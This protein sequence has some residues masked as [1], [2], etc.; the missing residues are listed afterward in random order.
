M[1]LLKKL[2]RKL[3]VIS[4]WW[5]NISSRCARKN[6][7]VWAVFI[8]TVVAGFFLSSKIFAVFEVFSEKNLFNSEVYVEG[9]MEPYVMAE[10]YGSRF[11]SLN[12]LY[13]RDW[14]AEVIK[15]TKHKEASPPVVARYLAYTASI[16]ADV[17]NE[18]NSQEQANV[19][20]AQFLKV[21]FPEKTREISDVLISFNFEE[22]ELNDEAR[23]VFNVYSDRLQDDGFNIVWN[24]ETRKEDSWYVQNESNVDKGAAAGE[25]K[26]WIVDKNFVDVSPPPKRGSLR[27]IVEINRAQHLIDHRQP[28]EEEGIF[29]W[30][31]VDNIISME[32]IT[33]AGIWQ[34]ILYIELGRTLDDATY[35]Q[36]QKLLS[37]SIADSLIVVWDVK[38]THLVQRPFMRIPRL[39]ILYSNP[40]YPSYPSSDAAVSVAASEVLSLLVPEKRDLWVK[41]AT[42][43]M[44]SV[45]LAGVNFDSDVVAGTH[46]GKWVAEEIL[47]NNDTQIHLDT[48][49]QKNKFK[50][51]YSNFRVVKDFLLLKTQSA[52]A[53]IVKFLKGEVQVKHFM[54]AT[55]E[56]GLR[57]GIERGRGVSWGD[58]NSDGNIDLLTSHG[59]YKNEGDG[60]FK[61]VASSES[62]A[63]FQAP[64]FFADYNNDGCLDVFFPRSG[65]R[66]DINTPGQSNFL[67]KGNCDG[68]FTDVTEESGLADSYHSTSASWADYN[69]DGYLDL[70]V[71]NLSIL[72]GSEIGVVPVHY[73]NE[74]NIL[75]RNNG[76]GT[77]TDVTEEAGRVDGILDCDFYNNSQIGRAINFKAPF[78]PIWFDYNNDNQID[79]FV[80]SDT[81]LSPLYHNN[82]D[83]TFTQVTQEAG[84]CEPNESSNMGAAVAD[85][86]N[87]GF[88]DIYITNMGSNSFWRNNG[89]GTFTDIVKETEADDTGVGWGTHF[90]DYDNDSDLDLLLVN[91]SPHMR[92]RYYVGSRRKPTDEGEFFENIGDG[93]FVKK[94]QILGFDYGNDATYSTAMAD[95]NNDG[96]PDVYIQLSGERH[97]NGHSILYKNTPNNNNWVK[98][99]LIGTKSNRDAIGARIYLTSGG[100][101]QMQEIIN[102]SSYVGQSSPWPIF[103]LG[104]TDNIEQVKIRW[105]SGIVQIFENLDINKK[106]IITEGRTD[107]EYK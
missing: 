96:F 38:Y 46:I 41:F 5:D 18:T 75:Y 43:S 21:L 24:G 55:K 72:M 66:E 60:T 54:D 98:F 88:L 9:N 42:D 87:N 91:G 64:G 14:T 8:L 51:R 70:Y 48:D 73:F 61:M 74:P 4:R 78:Q 90:L 65:P 57:L 7:A 71:I 45:L 84:L 92:S 103:G 53:G 105:P 11:Y 26:T 80:V 23:E 83:G 1:M 89:D 34:N 59:L 52:V 3:R 29:F 58:Y 79:L 47:Q 36:Y 17:L 62:G 32:T 67:Y 76:D 2:F 40:S 99:Q 82:G 28:T 50:T 35:A 33:V 69:N 19:V 86:N 20:T 27:D 16:Y 81:F 39:N 6:F 85:Y 95:Y 102:G 49:F 56:S 12:R 37:Q 94:G 30:R 100:K 10:F 68:T 13:S 44:N 63:Y 104:N 25:W 101:T 93:T 77:F 15:Y 31:G 22:A 107:V 97:P 106:V